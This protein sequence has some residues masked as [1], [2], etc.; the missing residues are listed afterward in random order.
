VRAELIEPVA[1]LDRRLKVAGENGENW[2]RYLDWDPMQSQ[3]RDVRQ[4]DLAVLD[5]VYKKYA[6]QRAYDLEKGGELY[7]EAT[8]SM[9]TI[10][11]SQ[12]GEREATLNSHPLAASSLAKTLTELN[13]PWQINV[14]TSR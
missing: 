5:A 13:F 10:S 4:P 3:L 9:A 11:I 6:A 7:I 14:K 12:P 8:R 1:R 2:R